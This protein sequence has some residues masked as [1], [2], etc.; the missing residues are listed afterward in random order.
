MNFHSLRSGV[1][2]PMGVNFHFVELIA[3]IKD[4]GVKD[5]KIKAE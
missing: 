1:N 3:K 5:I 4:F 2:C